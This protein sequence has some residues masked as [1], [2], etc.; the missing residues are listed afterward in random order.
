M[1]DR[2]LAVHCTFF[3]DDERQLL[4][5]AGVHV[6]LSPA[7]YGTTGESTLREGRTL[8]ELRDAG[9][10]VSLSTDGIGLPLGGMPE[11]MRQVWL[12]HNEL[13][14]DN[15][16]VLASGAL[17][18]ATRVAARGL[19]WENE[20]GSLSRGKQADIVLVPIDDWRYL[21]HPRPLEA[22]LALGG[23]MDVES[24]IVAGRILVDDR[25]LTV[26]DEQQLE[27]EYLEALGAFHRR[28][29]N[30]KERDGAA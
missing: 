22:F 25:R 26:A 30:A 24:V 28:V 20:I 1:T 19:R 16:A 29:T 4:S 3:D 14:A 9:L 15:T 21:R 12:G 2:L 27:R 7:K 8:L 23:S 6:N 11:A 13:A 5:D 17:A 18:M 10:E